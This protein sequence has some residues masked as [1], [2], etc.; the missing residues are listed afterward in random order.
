[1]ATSK[2]T[3]SRSSSAD[4]VTEFAKEVAKGTRIAGPHVRNQCARHLRT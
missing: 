4:P 1:M 3:P 2:K